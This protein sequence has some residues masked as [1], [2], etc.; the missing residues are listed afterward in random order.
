MSP[1]LSLSKGIKYSTYYSAVL[2][3]GGLNWGI[4]MNAVFEWIWNYPVFANFCYFAYLLF[5]NS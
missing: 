1:N 5:I 4:V 3:P 2:S